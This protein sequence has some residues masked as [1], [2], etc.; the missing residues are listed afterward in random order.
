MKKKIIVIL[1]ICL[2]LGLAIFILFL[3]KYNS[4]TQVD[5][6]EIVYEETDSKKENIIEDNQLKEEIEFSIG[7]ATE[8]IESVATP[9]EKEEIQKDNDKINDKKSEDKTQIINTNTT[10]ASTTKKEEN[11]EATKNVENSKNENKESSNNNEVTNKTEQKE[12]KDNTTKCNHSNEGYYITEDEAKAYYKELS[13]EFGEKVKDGEI[14][15]E[16]YL[17]KCPYGYETISCQYCGKWT[18]SLYYE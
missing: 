15:Y 9:K 2:F 16:E 17:K 10:S 13:K 11:K 18:I 6:N 4:G 14:T 12:E 1:I 5:N 7:N 3:N 8:Q